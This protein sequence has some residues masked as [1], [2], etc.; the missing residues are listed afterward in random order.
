MFKTKLYS[1]DCSKIQKELGHFPLYLLNT[2]LDINI[3]ITRDELY[4]GDI[5]INGITY[6]NEI[7][8]NSCELLKKVIIHELLHNYSMNHCGSYYC[9]MS[10]NPSRV[11]WD[12]KNDKPIFCLNCKKQLPLYIKNKIK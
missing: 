2:F 3:Y 12:V 1:Y 5:K 6:G 8:V 7:Y 11:T 9:I 10:N 4:S